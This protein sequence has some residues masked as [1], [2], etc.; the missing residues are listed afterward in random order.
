M[1]GHVEANETMSSRKFG[2]Q[3]VKGATV[4]QPAVDG[5]PR[6]TVGVA[7]LL[8][9]NVAYQVSVVELLGSVTRNV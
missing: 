8:A 3:G 6:V 5:D 9:C 4:V 7:P 2:R 1:S